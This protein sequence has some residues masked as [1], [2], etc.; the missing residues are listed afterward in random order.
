MTNFYTWLLDN[1][2]LFKH[3]KVKPFIDKCIDNLDLFSLNT[4]EDYVYYL[5]VNGYDSEVI[6]AFLRL[7]HAFKLS[8]ALVD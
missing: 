6:M 2:C 5:S 7:Y 4:E 8:V 3:P 1:Q